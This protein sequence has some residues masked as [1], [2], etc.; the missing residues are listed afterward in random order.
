MKIKGL[1]SAAKR[2]V[3]EGSTGS[4]TS[5]TTSHENVRQSKA[6]PD[7]D[8]RDADSLGNIMNTPI[9]IT[10]LC[11]LQFCNFLK[12]HT[13]AKGVIIGVKRP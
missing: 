13:L 4:G 2:R 7:D 9:L 8:D 1:S 3:R 5:F 10:T 11:N 6:Y 12:K